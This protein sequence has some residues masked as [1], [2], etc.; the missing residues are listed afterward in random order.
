MFCSHLYVVYLGIYK[1]DSRWFKPV[2]NESLINNKLL[3]Y[4]SDLAKDKANYNIV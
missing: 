1:T 2:V 3:R 4:D